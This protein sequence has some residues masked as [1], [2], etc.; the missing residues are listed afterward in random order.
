MII[1][2]IYIILISFLTMSVSNCKTT[3]TM[4]DSKVSEMTQEITGAYFQKWVAGVKGGGSGINLYIPAF[5]QDLMFEKVFFRGM[6]TSITKANHEGKEYYIGYFK[7]P[8]NSKAEMNLDEDAKNEYG[9]KSPLQT[10]KVKMP[11]EIADNEA[12][13]TYTENDET[14]YVKVTGITEKPMLAL[15]MQRKPDNR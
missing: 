6:E 8:L 11:F 9:N 4:N 7:T 15:P 13:I 5:S 12:I 1:K 3:K 10:E 2:T 14:K